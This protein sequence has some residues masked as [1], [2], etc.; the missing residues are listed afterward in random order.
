LYISKKNKYV[1]VFIYTANLDIHFES[2]I[3]HNIYIVYIMSKMPRVQPMKCMPGVVCLENY[4]ILFLLI[5]LGGAL[6][7][8]FFNSYNKN[9][10]KPHRHAN[11]NMHMPYPP[12]ADAWMGGLVSIPTRSD[13]F[14]DP[15]SPPLKYD[16]PFYG[17]PN[18]PDIRG[19]IPVNIKTR[20]TN[21]DFR[22][23]GILTRKN[24]IDDMI[25]PLM[26][27][28]LMSG[29]DKWTYYTISNNGNINTK[30]P[31]SVAGRSCTNEYGCDEIYNNDTVYVEGYKD[32]FNAT[33]YE[34]GTFSYIPVL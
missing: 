24:G 13:P 34:N 1:Y 16:M 10:K 21:T 26:G 7:F 9:R 3:L 33:V 5:V 31:I 2:S 18:I 11:M 12:V 6:Y 27:T 14:N 19:A 25:L 4:T 15:Y 28:R 32:V 22:Q 30:L 20:G 23:V 8:L 17:V 29:R